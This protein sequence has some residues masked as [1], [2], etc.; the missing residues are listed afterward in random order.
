MNLC[1]LVYISEAT[2]P[3]KIPQLDQLVAHS[4]E[5]NASRGISG[6]LLYSSGNFMQVLEG[7]ELIVD[8]LYTKIEADPRHTNVRRLLFKGAPRRMFPDWGMNLGITERVVAVDRES[9]DRVMLRLRLVRDNIER[10]ET[11]AL[12]LLQEFRRQLMKQ[13]A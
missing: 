7:D 1:T 2:T 3:F 6:L 10:V 9:V 4:H 5:T 13:A 11:E 8:T 12:T